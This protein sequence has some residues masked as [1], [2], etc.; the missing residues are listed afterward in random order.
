MPRIWN[1]LKRSSNFDARHES[2]TKYNLESR[3]RKRGISITPSRYQVGVWQ[4]SAL[5]NVYGDGSVVV[6]QS[7]CEIGQGN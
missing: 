3:W 1:E 6:H 7:G 2:V 5:V 4:K